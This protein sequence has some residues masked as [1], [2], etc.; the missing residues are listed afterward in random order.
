[1]SESGVPE[2]TISEY[3]RLYYNNNKEKI[4]EKRKQHYNNNREKINE[5]HRQY[6]QANKEKIREYSNQ[7]IECD[8][9]FGTYTNSNKTSH[10]KSKKHRFFVEEH[11]AEL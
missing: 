10:I 6:Y 7:K 8:I 1:M 9:C 5:C 2:R 3:N 4:R 11:A